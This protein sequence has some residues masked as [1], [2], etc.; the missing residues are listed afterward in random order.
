[1][2]GLMELIAV[3]SR[4][5]GS[6]VLGGMGYYFWRSYKTEKNKFFY[7]YF[8]FFSGMMVIQ[9]FAFLFDLVKFLD[10]TNP[11]GSL[12]TARFSD[13]SNN[14]D[15][16]ASNLMYVSNFVRPLYLAIFLVLLFAIGSQVY[17][18]E[19]LT[20]KKKKIISTLNFAWILFIL[21][22]YIPLEFFRYSFYTVVILTIAMVLIG[23]GLLYNIGMSLYLVFKT[24]G[25]VRRRSLLVLI[26]F[27]VMIL[28]M[29]WSSRIGLSKT[30]FGIEDS[31]FDVIFSSILI[32][33][34]SIIYYLG[35]KKSK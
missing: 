23:I 22:I 21:S 29:A 26:G 5:L 13:W 1:M 15:V 20:E 19:I 18:L 17:P 31:N 35:F 16:Y 2:S 27:F 34:S 32:G 11:I 24:I 4:G 10:P 28:G 14:P 7:G 33:V 3:I 9:F 30:F 12:S 25:D 8:L 6:L